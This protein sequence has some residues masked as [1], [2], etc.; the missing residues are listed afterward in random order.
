MKELA[1]IG[2]EGVQVLREALHCSGK[3]IGLGAV[4]TLAEMDIPAEA[5]MEEVLKQA[6]KL[7]MK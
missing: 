6:P 1:C 4:K 3:A 7:L 2:A 5:A